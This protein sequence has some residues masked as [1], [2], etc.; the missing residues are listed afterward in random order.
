MSAA[1]AMVAVAITA[2]DTDMARRGAL[3]RRPTPV[4]PH[5]LQLSAFWSVPT[6]AP[7]TTL[8]AGF[9]RSVVSD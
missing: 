3:P 4:N 2:M 5:P 1:V 8:T 7:I 6:A 9:A